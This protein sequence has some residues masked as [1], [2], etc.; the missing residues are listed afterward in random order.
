MRVVHEPVE[1]RVAKG[2][3]AHEVMPVLDRHLAR[4]ERGAP[5][6]AFFD[7]LEEVAPLTVAERGQA[8]V[9]QDE[10][11]RLPELLEELAIGAIGP[12]ASELIAQESGQ[13]GVAHRVTVAA[14]AL[15]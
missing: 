13:P 3:I 15:A 11:I 9:I 1:D 8:P 2:R 4:D 12:G 6:D 14:G 5:P 7:D 10:Q